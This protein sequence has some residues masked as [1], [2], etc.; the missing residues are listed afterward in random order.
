LPRRLLSSYSLCPFF[1]CCCFDILFFLRPHGN[2]PCFCDEQ[3]FSARYLTP[4][5]RLVA[6]PPRLFAFPRHRGSGCSFYLP[7]FASCFFG[8][9]PRGPPPESSAIAGL[10]PAVSKSLTSCLSIFASNGRNHFL[11]EISRVPLWPPYA[12]LP[13]HHLSLVPREY[14]AGF[15]YFPAHVGIPSVSW[16]S[17]SRPSTCDVSEQSD[18]K[19]GFPFSSR[20]NVLMTS[21]ARILI[22]LRV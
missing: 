16:L 19:A 18:L 15:P 14:R 9:Q 4:A 17:P 22:F 7:R 12:I 11:W 6:P 10:P 20:R 3:S 2:A 5:L 1:L 21:P 13:P 8:P